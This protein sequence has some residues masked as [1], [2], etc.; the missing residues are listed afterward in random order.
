M[1]P[2]AVA[3][4]VFLRSV[5]VVFR[6]VLVKVWE[7]KILCPVDNAHRSNPLIEPTGIGRR[8]FNLS[9]PVGSLS[10]CVAVHV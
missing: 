8:T 3:K 1:K 5:T 6:F 9:W 2:R 4:N 7:S 10:R